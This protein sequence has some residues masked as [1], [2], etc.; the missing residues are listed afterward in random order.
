MLA[1]VVLTVNTITMTHGHMMSARTDGQNFN[2]LALFLPRERDMRQLWWTM[3]STSLEGGASMV[4]IW[5]IWLHLNCPVSVF[6][7]ANLILPL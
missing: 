2:V 6:T 4:R 3:S 7:L 1:L 5:E